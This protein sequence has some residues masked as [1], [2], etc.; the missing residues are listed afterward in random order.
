MVK[1]VKVDLWKVK[2]LIRFMKGK[3]VDIRHETIAPL[4]NMSLSFVYFAYRI[5]STF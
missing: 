2:S 4:Q 3:E 5:I 1:K